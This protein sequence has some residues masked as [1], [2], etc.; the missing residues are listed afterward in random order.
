MKP[1]TI[2]DVAKEAGVSVSTVSR[3]INNNYPVSPRSREKVDVAVAKL[4]FSPS[5]FA[6]G[7]I[8]NKTY[9]VAVM[10][11]DFA[12][13][14][15]PAVVNSIHKYFRGKGYQILM[16]DTLADV[17]DERDCL[18]QLW[19]HHVDGLISI[20]PATALIQDGSYNSFAQ[21]TPLILIDGYHENVALDFVLNNQAQGVRKAMEY[22]HDLGHEKIVFLRGTNTF[23]YDVK[24]E[25]FH[26]TM[27][28]MNLPYMKEAV[29]C[30]EGGNSIET[31][32]TVV[33]LMDGY[34]R[35]PDRPTAVLA[36]ND[37]MAIGV[38]YAAQQLG[39]A[40]PDHLSVV[41]GDNIVIS[42]VS[43]PRLTTIDYNMKQLGLSAARELMV[44]IERKRD[45]HL[46]LIRDTRL[47]VRESSGPRLASP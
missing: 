19:K 39:I 29:V 13:L 44:N 38:L 12:N 45:G 34:L 11:P 20:G 14:F 15:F 22:L 43:R 5:I 23:S 16:C 4:K 2:Q 10:V 40:V 46:R 3:V 37:W 47:V 8:H 27:E 1:I 31:I 35:R 9:T 30:I 25:A 26:S 28:Q 36:C 41:G 21:H 32:E 7:L 33:K 6:R 18:N 24:E 17:D 42:E